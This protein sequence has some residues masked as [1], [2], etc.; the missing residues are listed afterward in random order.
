MPNLA[1]LKASLCCLELPHHL[2]EV[3]A[4]YIGANAMPYPYDM[5]GDAYLVADMYPASID[6]VCDEMNG[7]RSL[8]PALIPR[9]DRAGV[10]NE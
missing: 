6:R 9:T 3:T 7:F 1:V 5:P 10:W 2:L 4:R 8:R